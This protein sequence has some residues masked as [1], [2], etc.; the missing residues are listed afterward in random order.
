[1]S[2][3]SVRIVT[4][5]DAIAFRDGYAS[6]APVGSYR[7]NPFG[8]HDLIGNVAEWTRDTGPTDYDDCTWR[9]FT[10]ERISIGD[11]NKAA[12][13]GSYRSPYTKTRSAAREICGSTTRSSWIG[14]RPSRE[15]QSEPESDAELGR[16]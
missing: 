4:L 1:V 3:V 16:E 5:A 10:N 14:V 11:G 6:T 12:R 7:P 8:L 2:G 13:G 15:V 9:I